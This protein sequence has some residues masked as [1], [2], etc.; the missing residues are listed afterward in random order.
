MDQSALLEQTKDLVKEVTRGADTACAPTRKPCKGCSCGRAEE[1]EQEIEQKA[2]PTS[3]IKLDVT[4]LQ[5]G[6]TSLKS[7]CGNCYKG[8]AFR[9]A[10][11]PYLGKP[12]FEKGQEKVMLSLD[13]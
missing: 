8:D 13:G 12:A 5:E 10:S 6:P 11:C 3:T 7:E 9:C 4:E 2:N 1:Y